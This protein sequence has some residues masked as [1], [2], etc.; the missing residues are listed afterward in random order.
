MNIKMWAARPC[1]SSDLKKSVN[2]LCS[3]QFCGFSREHVVTDFV[4]QHAEEQN[5]CCLKLMT[6]LK[7]Q[8][9]RKILRTNPIQ[10]I[11]AAFVHQHFVGPAKLVGPLSDFCVTLGTPHWSHSR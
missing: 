3:M 4:E 10:T 8:E 9:S 6:A 11:V 7:W 5:S 2:S 1:P